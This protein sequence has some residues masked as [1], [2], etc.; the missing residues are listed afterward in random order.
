MK[1]IQRVDFVLRRLHRNVIRDSG[2]RIG[3]EIGRHLLGRTQADIDVGSDRAG[4]EAKLR[5]TAPVDLGVEGRRID[6]L[7]QMRIDDAGNCGNALPELLCNRKVCRINAHG[8][9]ID[10]RRQS[11]VQDLRYDI[12]RLKIEHIFR[13]CRRQHLTQFLDV[14]RRRLVAFLE[15]HL[16]DAVIDPD[17]RPIGKCQIVGSR[18]QSDIVDNQGAFFFGN[19]FTN[20]VLDRLEDR[21]RALDARSRGGANMKLDLSAVDQRE[22]VAPDKRNHHPPP[23]RGGARS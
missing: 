10:L 14:I 20:L 4:I 11:E 21:L 16:D 22:K 12:G 5:G 13:E 8:S 6:L 18:R 19:D 2:L 9:D 17:R 7:L 1:R 15:R 3:P 23:H